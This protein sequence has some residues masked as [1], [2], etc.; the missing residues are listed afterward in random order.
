M[1]I[2]NLKSFFLMKKFK[3]ILIISG[4]KSFKK[5]NGE[6]YIKKNLNHNSVKT[7]YFFKKLKNPEKKEL[8][9]IVQKIKKIKPELIVAL[10]GGCVMDYA[11]SANVLAHGNKSLNVNK[12]YSSNF[13]K[14]LCIPT[15]A[16]TGAEITPFAVLY[17]KKKKTNIEGSAVKPNFFYLEP[18]F[19]KFNSDYT[20]AS[21]GF[22]SFSQ[23][24]ESIIS[25]KANKQ[26][27]NYAK[28]S[29]SLTLSNLVKFY[30]F[31]KEINAKKLLLAANFS[32][33]AISISNTGAPHALSYLFST[34]F[35]L[36]HGHSV[37]LNSLK[38]IK[39]NYLNQNKDKILKKR[40]KILFNSLKCQNYFEFEKKLN[41]II[42][43]I[44]LE[45]NFKKLKINQ[46]KLFK[47]KKFVNLKRLKNN[48]IK[49][50]S[51]D[52]DNILF[53]R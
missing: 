32:G 47:L 38:I 2:K 23:S 46:K 44:K 41:Y 10:G 25:I 15:T 27:I 24:M 14:L 1:E 6:K 9:L 11:K 16:G 7:H 50:N 39:F 8:L 22:D 3:N 17:I 42:K 40:L 21:S 29:I 48:I 34:H 18:S 45:Q 5:I 53:K 52:I 26:S 4:K 37:S 19:I 30:K 12:K 33:K 43:T 20:I 28:K 13:C 31:K 51:K 35:G 36:S 49:I